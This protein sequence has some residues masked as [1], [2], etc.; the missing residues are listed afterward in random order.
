LQDS[1]CLVEVADLPEDSDPDE[2]IRQHGASFFKEIL[3]RAKPLSEY[4]LEVLKRRY[5]PSSE[6][7]RLRFLE[8]ALL[9]LREMPNLVERDIY[10]QRVAEELG[11]SEGACPAGAAAAAQKSESKRQT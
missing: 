5:D 1:G 10:L 8:E 2:L 3:A 6:E 9:M 7:S 11:V 4:R